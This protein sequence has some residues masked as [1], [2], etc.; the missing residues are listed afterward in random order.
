[1]ALRLA[2]SSIR[3][4]YVLLQYLNKKTVRIFSKYCVEEANFV[5][6]RTGFLTPFLNFAVA[7]TRQIFDAV[8]ITGESEVPRGTCVA[9]LLNPVTFNPY[10]SIISHV[11]LGF[12]LQHEAEPKCLVI[13]RLQT[14]SES[15]IL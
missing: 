7:T 3:L 2:V 6:V 5:A 9:V 11:N 12:W 15:G 4:H 1:M 13:T 14:S 8:V 10:Y